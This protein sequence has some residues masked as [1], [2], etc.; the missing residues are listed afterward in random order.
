MKKKIL[1][2]EDD[3]TTRLFLREVLTA[4][5]FAASTA[6]N[7]ATGLKRARSA[8]FDL[9]LTDIWMPRMNGLELLAHLRSKPTNTP[10]VV[11]TSDGTPETLLRAVREHAYQYIA[12]PI[13]PARLVELVQD[14]VSAAPVSPPIEV[15]SAQP[16]WVEL[17]V[18]CD[19]RVA[20]RIQGFMVQ[21]KADLPEEVRDE[22]GRAFHELLS[23]AIE[24]GGKLDPNR[25]VRIAYLRAQHMLLYRIADPGPGFRVEE[26]THAAISYPADQPMEHMAAREQKGLRPGGFGIVLARATVDEL[27]YNEARNE[28]VFVKYLHRPASGLRQNGQETDRKDGEDAE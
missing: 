9:I 26:L 18:P 10:V 3:R 28:V 23:N 27:L 19:L 7:G 11:M 12:K 24:W 20:E 5:G 4:A 8:E 15:V 21:L 2:V 13:D 1:I 14:A 22:V 16:H 25:K 6:A 17:L